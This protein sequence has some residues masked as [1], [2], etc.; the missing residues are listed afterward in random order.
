M[1]I[2][3]NLLMM[4]MM[5]NINAVATASNSM[6]CQVEVFSTFCGSGKISLDINEKNEFTLSY[7]DIRCWMADIEYE[8]RLK[9]TEGTRIGYPRDTTLHALRVNPVSYGYPE[10]F[11][12]RIGE[13]EVDLKKSIA[14]LQLDEPVSYT[15]LT[16]P[17][18]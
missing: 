16:L 18:T 2:K 1:Q 5:L 9:A 3:Q 17:T 6:K 7:G 13:L 12:T 11:D 10:I 15:H 14:H 8:G 4:V